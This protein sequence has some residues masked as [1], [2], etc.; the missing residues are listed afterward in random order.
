MKSNQHFS[1][2]RYS[3]DHSLIFSC[4]GLPIFFPWEGFVIYFMQKG[5]EKLN[6]AVLGLCGQIVL[7]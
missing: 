7:W 1:V 3:K 5:I 6:V 2:C 4:K